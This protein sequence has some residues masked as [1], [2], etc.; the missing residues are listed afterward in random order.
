MVKKEPKDWVID[1]DSRC[2]VDRSMI[3]FIAISLLSGN[4]ML[5]LKPIGSVQPP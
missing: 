4:L 1:R 3:I 5:L 2:A